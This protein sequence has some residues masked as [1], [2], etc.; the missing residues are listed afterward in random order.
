MSDEKDRG[1][2]GLIPSAAGEIAVRSTSIVR[3]GRL[4]L[5]AQRPTEDSTIAQLRE[6]AEWDGQIP[7]NDVQAAQ[8]FR[9][10]AAGDAEAQDSLGWYY[11]LGFAKDEVQAHHW[12]RMAAEQGHA[13]AQYM[14][15]WTYTEGLGVP[16]D[17]VEAV[18][19]YRKSAE[20]GEPY[21]QDS[22]GMAYSDGRGVSRDDRQ[23]FV[24]YSKAAEQGN[25]GGQYH[26]ANAYRAGCGVPQD[27][28]EAF[29]WYWRAAQQLE[30][31]AMYQLALMY[32]AGQSVTKDD[33]EAFKWCSL[34]TKWGNFMSAENRKE[35]ADQR[36]RI[37]A[38]LTPD[39]LIEG[40][41]RARE[42]RAAFE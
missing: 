5:D 24:W 17:H 25:R 29:A 9:K 16:V 22:L 14:V 30:E 11:S 13:N 32:S 35:Y 21:A 36:D 7:Q 1:P 41:K 18:R 8:C 27:Y 19:W 20:Q 33:V 23:A 10:A 26:L 31:D 42:F 39:E 34:A 28:G 12:Y 6:A 38:K 37:A 4:L 3:R 15:G 2:D 40:Q